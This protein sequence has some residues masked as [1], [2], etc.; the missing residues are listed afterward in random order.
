VSEMRL[1]EKTQNQSNLMTEVLPE[2]VAM[3]ALTQQFYL[4]APPNRVSHRLGRRGG[5]ALINSIGNLGG[6]CWPLCH[7]QS[8]PLFLLQMTE[9]LVPRRRYSRRS[10]IHGTLA[11]PSRQLEQ[12]QKG[13]VAGTV[14]ADVTI[15]QLEPMVGLFGCSQGPGRRR[16][17]AGPI[18]SFRPPQLELAI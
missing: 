2:L 17:D 5:I 11:A 10:L 13:P 18:V 1:Y 8:L 7:R 6:F 15:A 9:P 3:G 16:P 12:T 4:L 14:I